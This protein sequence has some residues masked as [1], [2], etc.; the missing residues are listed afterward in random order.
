MLHRA[1]LI[2][3]M[4]RDREGGKQWRDDLLPWLKERQ[5]IAFNPYQKPALDKG[6]FED[7][8]A[9]VARHKAKVEGDYNFVRQNMKQ[10][11]AFDLRMVDHSD[12]LI[13][14]LDIH[15]HPCG[16]YEELFSG[17]RQ[18]KPIITRC[19]HGKKNMPDW[20]FGV[21]PHETMFDTWD[22]VKEY[23]RH[24]D[25]DME[26]DT[27]GRWQFFD[28]ENAIREILNVKPKRNAE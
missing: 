5:I 14:N 16:T 18:K 3:A 4:D 22:E 8:D 19:A 24:I 15:Q 12:F 17:N 28:L 10:V 21:Y 26:I 6:T 23:I 2:G 1:Y 9:F 7:D 20:L 11:R 13:L 27:L 25:E